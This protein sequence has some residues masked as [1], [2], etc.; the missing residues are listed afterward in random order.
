MNNRTLSHQDYCRASERLRVEVG[1]LYALVE[2]ECA[3]SGFLPD[4]RPSILF[5]RHIFH[6]QSGGRFSRSHPDISNP[7]SG[8]Y[9]GGRAEWER[10]ERAKALDETAALKSA[11]WGLGQVMGFNYKI[12]GWSSVQAFVEA[13]GES[14]AVQLEAVE[15]FLKA[16]GLDDKLRAKDWRGFARGYNG[17]AYARLGYHTKLENAYRKHSHKVCA[18]APTSS[19]HAAPAPEEPPPPS[20]S[21]SIQLADVITYYRGLPHQR[22]AI[23]LWQRGT[24]REVLE[25]VS[26]VWRNP[27]RGSVPLT[28]PQ[29]SPSPK[30]IPTH[31][32][33]AMGLG[34]SS[35]LL[36]GDLTFYDDAGNQLL[37]C[38]AT[39][40]LPRTQN[41]DDFY[42]RGRGLIPPIEGMAIRTEPVDLPHLPGVDGLFY[43]IVKASD[44][45][46]IPFIDPHYKRG[47]FGLHYDGNAPGSAGC[48]V[49]LDKETF[50]Q[51]VVPLLQ[52]APKL[53]S[54]KIDYS[55]T[56][57][58]T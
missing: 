42:K 13:M 45:D 4:G 40:G 50:T 57:I 12:A 18:P 27:T 1:L 16:N 47:D 54:L 56:L 33:F 38:K 6:K 28:T 29:P 24:P 41:K 9:K 7:R 53:L 49:V 43:P 14:E 22:E 46:T 5:E 32:T 34:D 31:A 25:A 44:P 30:G 35:K 55:R 17:P 2:V 20:D 19:S 37:T 15:N 3:R 8:G 39:S 26:Q 58:S 51:K 11:S 48:I 10:L 21:A 36:V 52:D 23:R